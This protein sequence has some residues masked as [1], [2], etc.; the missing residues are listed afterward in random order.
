MRGAMIR[1]LSLRF[2]GVLEDSEDHEFRGSHRCD[3]DLANKPTVQDV[4]GR[5]DGLIAGDEESLFLRSPVE[6]AEP[7]LCAQENPDRVGYPGPESRIVRL[8]DHPLRAVVD[9]MLQENEKSPYTDVFPQRVGSDV[10]RA[11][12]AYS[13]AGE[14][15]D[16][17]DPLR[18]EHV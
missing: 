6:R 15:P 11:P 17:V 7:P 5:H 16:R 14:A 13:A 4:V 9:R 10:A 3:S 1:P 18:I 8:K 2:G 12:Y